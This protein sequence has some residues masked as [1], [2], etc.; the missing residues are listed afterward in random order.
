VGIWGLLFIFLLPF[1]NLGFDLTDEGWQLAKAWGISHGDFKNNADLIWGSSFF[2]GLWLLI[3]NEPSLLWSRIAYL[4]FIPFFGTV[5]YSMLKEFYPQK[6]VFFSVVTAFLIFNKTLLIYS[7]VNYY[8]LPVFASLLSF[9]FLIKF[10]NSEKYSLSYIILSGFFA[11]VSILLKFTYILIIPVFL[12]YLFLFF[13]K[14]SSVSKSLIIYYGSLFSA[15]LAGFIIL[16]FLGGAGD[17]VYEHNRLSIFSMFD[18]FL[19]GSTVNSSLNYSAQ[20]L[21]GIY[22]KDTIS[23]LNFALIPL[24][25]LFLCSHFYTKNSKLR[26]LILLIFCTI[27]YLY[28]YQIFSDSHLKMISAV[29]GIAT[30]F[31]FVLKRTDSNFSLLFFIFISGFALSFLG[32]G[33][34]FYGGVFSLGFMGFSA[35]T[36]SAAASIDSPK[37]NSRIVLPIFFIIALITQFSKSYS[38]YRDLPSEYLNVEFKSPELNGIYS[39]KERVETVDEFLDFANRVV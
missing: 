23:V 5:I 12:I 3:K 37:I 28:I 15:V 35:F 36:L 39:F 8:Y 14:K 25:L 16:L 18:Y 33:T 6:Y 32:S 38:P 17:L 26:Y 20:N 10:H 29:L 4:F 11:G 9:L 27:L 34:G 1:Y 31:L 2:N 30:Y 21:L 22:F 7:S 19:G 24:L 13:E